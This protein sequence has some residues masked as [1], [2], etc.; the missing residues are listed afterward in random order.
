MSATDNNSN[1]GHSRKEQEILRA[2]LFEEKDKIKCAL[3][4]KLLPSQI[5]IAAHIKTRNKC[6]IEERIDL[7]IVMPVCE[8]GCDDLFEKGY[9]EIDG[10][11]NILIN[12]SKK[13]T[14]ELNAFMQQYENKKCLFCNDNT[15]AYFEFRNTLS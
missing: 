3:C 11:G 12:N 1:K 7:N 10:M 5:M 4:H 9:L 2:F 13:I 8:I 15:Q 6:S 14:N